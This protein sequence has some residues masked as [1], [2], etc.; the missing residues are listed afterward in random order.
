MLSMCRHD[1]TAP[2]LDPGYSM[3][4]WSILTNPAAFAA[5]MI[6]GWVVRTGDGFT[7]AEVVYGVADPDVT[8]LPEYGVSP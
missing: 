4:T 6:P 3:P 7:S 5:V 2:G 8:A 1:R